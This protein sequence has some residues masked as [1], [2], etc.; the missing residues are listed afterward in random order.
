VLKQVLLPFL[1]AHAAACALTVESR[2]I[3]IDC[4]L[5]SP[6]AKSVTDLLFS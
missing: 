1:N 2:C 5:K 4:Q 3:G 6:G